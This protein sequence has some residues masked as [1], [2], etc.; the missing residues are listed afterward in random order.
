MPYIYRVRRS[1]VAHG[2]TTTVIAR[3]VVADAEEPDRKE[4]NGNLRTADDGKGGVVLESTENFDA[5]TKD[6][7]QQRLRDAGRPVS[8]TKDELIARLQEPVG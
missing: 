3:P 6:E 4:G 8:G 5:L 1:D 2:D 7:L